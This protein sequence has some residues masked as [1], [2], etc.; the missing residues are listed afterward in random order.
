MIKAEFLAGFRIRDPA[1]NPVQ[2]PVR[3]AR[4]LFAF[5]AI[6]SGRLFARIRLADLLWKSS[7]DKHARQSLRRCLLDLRR[8]LGGAAEKVLRVDGDKLGVVRGAVAVDV[9]IFRE[10]VAAGNHVAAAALLADG[11]LLD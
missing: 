8:A 11:E 2:V 1:G 7:S 10:L 4:A 3:K 9:L 5:L 6:N